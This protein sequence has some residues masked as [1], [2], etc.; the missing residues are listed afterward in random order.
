MLIKS[1]F[2][3]VIKQTGDSSSNVV[4]CVKKILKQSK[5]G[6]LGTLD[7]AASGVLPVAFGKATKFFDYFLKKDKEYVADVLFGVETDTLDSFG[8]I[9]KQNKKII[10]KQDIEQVL[11]E[12]IGKINQ[13]PP[14]YSAVKIDGKK[15]CD[16]AREGKSVELKS[17]EIE[18]FSIDLLDEIDENFFRFKVYCSAGTYIRT[19]FSD[20]A[21]KLETVATTP[22]IIRTKSGAFDIENAATLD[23]LKENMTV[24]KIED[25]FSNCKF[26]EVSE[27]EL[28]KKLLNGV[29]LEKSELNFD[30]SENFFLTTN[31]SLIGMYHYEG[32][33]LICDVFLFE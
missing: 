30:S 16:L 32:L 10:K 24:L 22:V 17:R 18:I 13:T 21:T 15:A 7:P 26:H 9:T 5:V 8:K 25:L 3:N 2:V 19:L 28:L 29:K 6:H 23:E 27:N 12:F 1:G 4:C 11:P 33:K 31:G 14:S 20:I